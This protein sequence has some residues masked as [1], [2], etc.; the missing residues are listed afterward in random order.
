MVFRFRKSRV[1]ICKLVTTVQDQEKHFKTESS[2][3]KHKRLL[4]EFDEKIANSK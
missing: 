3:L 1:F 2:K 4:K